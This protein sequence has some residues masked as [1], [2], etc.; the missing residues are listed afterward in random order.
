[1]KHDLQLLQIAN[2]IPVRGDLL[3][4]SYFAE[5]F[6]LNPTMVSFAEQAP[7]TR[8]IDAVS[9]LKEVFDGISQEY[10]AC[11]VFNKKTPRE[12]VRDAVDRTRVIMD[13][14]K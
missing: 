8:G 12:A 13:W 2:Q 14:N 11:S 7:Y 4:N 9:D 10:E 3:T 6:R 5:Y 1:V